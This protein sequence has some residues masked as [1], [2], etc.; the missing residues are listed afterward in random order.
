MNGA[1]AKRLV[2]L[3]GGTRTNRAL[4]EQDP[5]TVLSDFTVKAAGS[6]AIVPLSIGAIFGAADPVTDTF[7]PTCLLRSTAVLDSVSV[8]DIMESFFIVSIAISFFVEGSFIECAP[9]A[10]V[11]AT[12]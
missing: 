1:A 4:Y 6:F 8:V 3:G 12:A 11:G 10:S 9:V 7:C 5:E 2:R